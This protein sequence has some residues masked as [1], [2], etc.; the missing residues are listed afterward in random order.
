MDG[1][2]G[3][4][5]PADPVSRAEFVKLATGTFQALPGTVQSPPEWEDVPGGAWYYEYAQLAGR[6]LLMPGEARRFSPERPLTR[7][8]AAT[9]IARG[10]TWSRPEVN[11]RDGTSGE[12]GQPYSDWQEVMPWAQAAV[13]FTTQLGIFEGDH[14]ERFRPQTWLT[15]GPKPQPSSGGPWRPPQWPVAGVPAG[16]EPSRSWP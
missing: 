6:S 15:P 8:E 14:R 7:Q 5:R 4:Y 13:A 3:S 9:V 10:L 16:R 12:S 2:D 1:Y 11:M